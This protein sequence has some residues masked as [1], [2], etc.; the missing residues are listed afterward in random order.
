MIP[1]KQE[2]P[3]KDFSKT[4]KD[5]IIGCVTKNNC[6]MQNNRSRSKICRILFVQTKD[7]KGGHELFCGSLVLH[8]IKVRSI[9]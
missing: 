5:H 2:Q 8:Q 4:G 6:I 3:C 9:M 1:N 7:E